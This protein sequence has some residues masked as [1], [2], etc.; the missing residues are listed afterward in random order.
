MIT[1]SSFIL[2]A[3]IIY[4]VFKMEEA[5]DKIEQEDRQYEYDKLSDVTD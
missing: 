2:G 1:Y 3:V 5:A 4:I